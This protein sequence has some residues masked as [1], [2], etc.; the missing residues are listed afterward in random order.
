M[1][2]GG[3]ETSVDGK[4]DPDG[5]KTSGNVIM[6]H[7]GRWS[8]PK[9]AA[10]ADVTLVGDDITEEGLVL[11]G[12]EMAGKERMKKLDVDVNP[13]ASIMTFRLA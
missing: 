12:V 13:R 4:M 11:A 5:R 2:S 3:R 10:A 1:H 7:G 8:A 9:W 6:D